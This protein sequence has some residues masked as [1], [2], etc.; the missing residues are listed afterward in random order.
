[1]CP[2]CITTVA[3][4]VAG[5]SSTG[6]L[7]ALVAMKIRTK[8]GVMKVDPKPKPKEIEPCPRSHSRAR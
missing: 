4:M 8:I 6:G 7:S 2:A 5:A 1:M 3:F